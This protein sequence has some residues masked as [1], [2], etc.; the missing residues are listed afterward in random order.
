[1]NLYS[2]YQDIKSVSAFEVLG[3]RLQAALTLSYIGP[4]EML[5]IDDTWVLSA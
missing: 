4:Y 2:S 1:M 5:A 3:A